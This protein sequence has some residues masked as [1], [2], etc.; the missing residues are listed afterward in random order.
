MNAL[1]NSQQE[2]LGK[3][4]RNAPGLVE[5]ARYTGQE[6]K[7]AREAIAQSPPDI[8]LTNFMMLELLLTR[9]EPL[10]RQVI[11]NCEGLEFLVLDELHTYRGRQGADVAMLVRRL[12]ERLTP[13]GAQQ[14]I[15][16]SATMAN[17]RPREMRAS[18]DHDPADHIAAGQV[19]H[20][21]KEAVRGLIQPTVAQ[22]MSRER[23][24]RLRP[25]RGGRAPRARASRIDRARAAARRRPPTR[26]RLVDRIR[27]MEPSL[28]PRPARPS[29]VLSGL[30]RLI[31]TTRKVRRAVF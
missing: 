19:A 13:G 7:E 26:D 11:A 21:Q 4:A 16:T 10:D 27:Q 29:A 8:L 2:E 5:F 3:F 15:G 23:A 9:Q 17:G 20:E 30:L 6:S 1:A 31:F 25:R 22:I 24:P 14:C 18:T 12:R 28:R